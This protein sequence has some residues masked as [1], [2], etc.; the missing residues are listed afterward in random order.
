[1]VK[2]VAVAAIANNRVIG[3]RE[4]NEMPW[5]LNQYAN[6]PL[7]N[8][9][10]NPASLRAHDMKHFKELTKDYSLIM[11]K[12]TWK[13]IPKSARPLKGR[14][15]HVISSTLQPVDG[16]YVHT[17]IDDALTQIRDTSKNII[18]MGGFG[19]YQEAMSRKL[20]DEIL[21][22]R[23]HHDFVGDVLF[24]EIT[25]QYQQVSSKPFWTHPVSNVQATIDT[26]RPK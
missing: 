26:Y 8:D 5:R 7:W 15:N 21:I 23:I 11:G 19:I 2:K 18:F 10:K 24:P 25:D 14:E 22:T 12:A 9:W 20:L 6:D 1:M 13:S 17:S 16:M 4:K 3:L